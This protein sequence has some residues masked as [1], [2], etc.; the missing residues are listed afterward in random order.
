MGFVDGGTVKL[1]KLSGTVVAA[2][3]KTGLKG[4]FTALE[5]RLVALVG[6][7][8]NPVRLLRSLWSGAKLDALRDGPLDKHGAGSRILDASANVSEAE[9]AR[10]AGFGKDQATP[11]GGTELGAHAARHHDLH[12]RELRT[13]KGSRRAI[14]RLL[15]NGEWPV[16]LGIMG[17][18][19]G[20][21][22]YLSVA[23]VR[24]LLAER[25]LPDEDRAAPCV[26]CGGAAR[27]TAAHAREGGPWSGRRCLHRDR[28]D[29]GIP[30]HV[31]KVAP[32]MLARILPPELP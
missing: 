32:P 1:S 29:R 11:D 5:T 10:F 13:R 20:E 19:E 12:G 9:L 17:K 4:R 16:L 14:G 28:G 21:G 3:G 30:N 22:R 6:N 25:R 24:A 31:R 23:E 18:G 7:G 8:F 2:S 27:R 15:M 26:A